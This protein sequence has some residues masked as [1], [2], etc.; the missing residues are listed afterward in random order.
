M[1]DQAAPVMYT[2]RE[3]SQCINFC[4]LFKMSD[5]KIADGTWAIDLYMIFYACVSELE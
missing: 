3:K 1:V 5:D 2:A 4:F